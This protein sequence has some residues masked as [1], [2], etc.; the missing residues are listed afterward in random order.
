[1]TH[2]EMVNDSIAVAAAANP[3]WLPYVHGPSPV[4]AW[5]LQV[6]GIVWILIQMGRWLYTCLK[7]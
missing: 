4:L 5:V 1:M 2:G 6:L 3:I 7:R